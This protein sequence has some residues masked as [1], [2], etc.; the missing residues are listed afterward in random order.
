MTRFVLFTSH[1][2]KPSSRPQSHLF[3]FVYFV[4]F[5]VTRSRRA[6]GK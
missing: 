4:Y 5:V 1:A 3:P 2:R 6:A